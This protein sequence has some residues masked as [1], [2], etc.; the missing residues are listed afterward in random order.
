MTIWDFME[1]EEVIFLIRESSFVSENL[2]DLSGF[3][4][5]K[6]ELDIR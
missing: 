1:K 3:I 2:F 4:P 5:Q 6:W